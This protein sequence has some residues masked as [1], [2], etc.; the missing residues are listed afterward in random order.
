MFRTTWTD[1][2]HSEWMAQLPVIVQGKPTD[3]CT[4][5]DPTRAIMLSGHGC[6]T[7]LSASVKLRNGGLCLSG[8]LTCGGFTPYAAKSHKAL[9]VGW[10][11]VFLV[12][13][14]IQKPARLGTMK[15]RCLH[16]ADICSLQPLLAFD[17]SNSTVW[18]CSSVR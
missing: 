2:A 11:F 13:T 15:L 1:D 16:R 3:E 10:S 5:A 4:F 7:T 6:L 8:V 12:S 18:P 17:T 9:L 14:S